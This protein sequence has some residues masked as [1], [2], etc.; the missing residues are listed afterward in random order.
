MCVMV[1]MGLIQM[2]PD[3][4]D[5]NLMISWGITQINLNLYLALLQP[6]SLSKQTPTLPLFLDSKLKTPHNARSYSEEAIYN[7]DDLGR[8][9][10]N[11]TNERCPKFL[12]GL[13]DSMYF[14]GLPGLDTQTD[15][16]KFLDIYSPATVNDSLPEPDAI[17]SPT[18][19]QCQPA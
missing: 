19:S 17:L 10:H 13:G 5:T 14:A 12:Q 18:Y 4:S 15:K 9:S 8:K 1:V 16:Q 3:K 2:R 6:T 11:F 7:T